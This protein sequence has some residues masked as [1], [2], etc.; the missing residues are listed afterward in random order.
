MVDPGILEGDFFSSGGRSQMQGL[1]AQPPAAEEV[2]LFKSLQSNKNLTFF[3]QTIP[4]Y[5]YLP[6]HAV[7][8]C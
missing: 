1:G 2:L 8:G 6:C 7:A 5:G 4:S 3:V